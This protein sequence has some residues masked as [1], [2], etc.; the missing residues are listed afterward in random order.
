M[1]PPL[2]RIMAG[3]RRAL[4]ARLVANGFAQ[5]FVGLASA[6]L[7]MHA[8]SLMVAARSP[9]AV[10]LA[11]VAAAL[12][13]CALALG[14]LRARERVDAERMGQGYARELRSVLFDQL[15]RLSLRALQLRRRGSLMLRFVGDL[16]SFRQWLS[17]GLSRLTVSTVSTT[18]ALLGLAVIDAA[19]AATALA[20]LLGG[21]ALTLRLGTRAQASVR[22]AR[23]RQARLAANLGEKLAS[24]PVVQL[25][26]QIRRER[27]RLDRQGARLEGAMV[28]QARAQARLRS[29]AEVT[30]HVAAAAVLVVGVLQVASGTATVPQIAAAMTLV[31][32]MVPAL[33]DLGLVHSYYTAATVSRERIC[34]FL[35]QPVL[36]DSV[37]PTLGL[38]AVRGSVEFR[39]VSLGQSLSG[40]SATAAPGKITAIIGP[41]GAGKST[42]LALAARQLDPD[43]G[44]VLIDGQ[45]LSSVTI[46]SVRRSVG[47]VGAD[48]PLLRGSLERNLRYRWPN[49][50]EDEVAR[51]RRLCR[52][53]EIV[54]S[55]PA[56]ARF[57]VQEG[58]AN[59]SLGQRQRISLA[60]ALLG[61]PAVL[62]LDEADVNLDQ[63]AS[64]ILDD[65]L[66]SHG[67]TVL[68]VTHCFERAARA[69]SVWVLNQ[70]RLMAVGS[71]HE[72]LSDPLFQSLLVPERSE[73]REAA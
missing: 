58:G 7:T 19:L 26:G 35:A 30:A 43:C 49:A 52:I 3:D 29:S 23:R 21:T 13:A 63:Q 6:R 22:L 10:D 17:L 2:P 68:M 40:F 51:V 53:D 69:D 34:S 8:F 9:D 65:V 27:Q 31:G 66:R 32:L 72:V 67:G 38:I 5:A 42:L 14:W 61:N 70:G 24:M 15:G 25:F 28:D 73:E 62:L 46:A 71:P 41:N 44:S 36:P 18:A 20:V 47:M 45:A 16:K 59:L 11:V 48:L 57:E 33:R 50:P 56:G 12:C 4:F 55:L 60:R 37:P 64:R 1:Q 54:A 39:D